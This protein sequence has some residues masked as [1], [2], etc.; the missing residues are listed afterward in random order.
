MSIKLPYLKIARSYEGY[1]PAD[2]NAV[3]A[4]ALQLSEKHPCYLEMADGEQQHCLFFRESQ[5]YSA[6]KIDG[7]QFGDTSIKDFLLTAGQLMSPRMTCYGVNNKILHSLLILFQKKPALKLLTSLVDLDQVLDKIEEEGKS[8]IVCAMQD[9]FLALLRYEKGRVT[10]LCHQESSPTPKER[11]FREDFLIKIYTLSAERPLEITV[12]EDLLVKYASDAKMIDE[13]HLGDVTNLY[14]S[15]PPVVTLVFKKKEIGHWILDKPVFNIGRTADNDIVI[16][17]LAVSRLH[18]VLEKEKGDYY[19]RDCDSLNGTVLNNQKVGRA[20]LR[21]GDQIVIGKHTLKIQSQT[22]VE[23][24][25]G[26]DIAPF[27]QTV[28]FG[29]GQVPEQPA[30]PGNGEGSAPRLLEKTGSGQSEISLHKPIVMGKDDEADVEIN[31]FFVAAQ[32]AEIVPENGGHVLR[33]INGYRKVTVGGKPVKEHVLQNHD[34][35]RIGKHEFIY[36][37]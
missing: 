9:S 14:L 28:V 20:K 17:N 31:G 27:D 6:G 3:V 24:A 4:E 10:A 25:G 1:S 22:G 11:N 19:I 26:P 16:D 12:Y 13:H 8:R 18:A 2:L 23:V 21:S 36:E 30:S 7:T 5:I 32:H 37:E 35:I 29:P 34:A 33:H 15:K